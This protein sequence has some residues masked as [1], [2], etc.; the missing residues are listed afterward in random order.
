MLLLILAGCG[1]EHDTVN[2]PYGGRARWIDDREY[3]LDPEG[4]RRLEV[5][6]TNGSIEIAAPGTRS[7]VQAHV[8]VRA[9]TEAEAEDFAARIE[10]RLT[11]VDDLCAIHSLYPDPAEGVEVEVSF[12]VECQ[13]EID[14]YLSTVNGAVEIAGTRG[15]VRASAVN[16][17]ILSRAEFSEAGGA[18][19]VT[20]GSIDVK[21]PAIDGPLSAT[22]ISGRIDF[23]L[24]AGFAGLLQAQTVN[25]T[26]LCDVLLSDVQHQ[27]PTSLYARVGEG[28]DTLIN[29]LCVNGDI[30]IGL[31]EIP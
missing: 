12:R 31:D 8:V 21:A 13:R 16:G 23:F 22:T 10:T 2:D 19:S 20:N 4:L 25:G 6:T 30:G 28:S 27:S 14:L 3:R 5:Y 11:R 15:R 7:V 9:D 18:L 29:L 26:V 24:P 17:S 1:D